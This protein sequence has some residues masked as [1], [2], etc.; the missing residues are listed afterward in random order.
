MV[1][2]FLSLAGCVNQNGQVLLHL[3]LADQIGQLLGA[4]R[5]IDAVVGF[6]FGVDGAATP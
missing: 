6:G 4:E 3:V 2:R 5:I 1:E